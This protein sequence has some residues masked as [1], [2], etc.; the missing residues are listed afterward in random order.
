MINTITAINRSTWLK[1]IWQINPTA[2]SISK[3]T[4]IAQNI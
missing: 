2:Q 3:I 1:T 4:K